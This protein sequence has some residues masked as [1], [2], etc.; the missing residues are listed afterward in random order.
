[1]LINI[2]VFFKALGLLFRAILSA[3]FTI[4]YWV[5]I[6]FFI[7][8]F[9]NIIWLKWVL[10]FFSGGGF[11]YSV[12]DVI[13]EYVH[14]ETGKALKSEGRLKTDIKNDAFNPN[15]NYG[16]MNINVPTLKEGIWNWA[17]AI[18]WVGLFLFSLKFSF[19]G[20]A[21]KYIFCRGL[22][23][24]K[25][26]VSSGCYDKGEKEPEDKW[27]DIPCMK[28]L[29]YGDPMEPNPDYVGPEVKCEN[30]KP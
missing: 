1:M 5:I 10:L 29:K 12:Y 2:L 22:E 20:L 24:G 26:P 7:L 3:W 25:P 30:Q 11:C 8:K 18:F 21:N 4:A 15:D 27:E 6:I 9:I 16:G 23:E 28:G 13:A 14:K 17:K 19:P